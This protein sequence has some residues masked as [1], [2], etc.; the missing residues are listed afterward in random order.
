VCG[1]NVVEQMFDI[2]YRQNWTIVLS[3]NWGDS[4]YTSGTSLQI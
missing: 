1:A 2:S 4:H 3:V